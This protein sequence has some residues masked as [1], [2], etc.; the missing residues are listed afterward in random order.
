MKTLDLIVTEN[1]IALYIDGVHRL[2]SCEG[3]ES[4]DWIDILREA[5]V[6][7]N[8]IMADTDDLFPTDEDYGNYP[9]TI[10]ELR[11]LLAAG[12]KA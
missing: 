2:D 1:E 9:E 6:D 10:D 3:L 5:G 7:A 8:L 11:T 12:K 4:F